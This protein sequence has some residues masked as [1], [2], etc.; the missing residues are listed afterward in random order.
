MYIQ[1][2]AAVPDLGSEVVAWWLHRPRVLPPSSFCSQFG[3]HVH[4]LASWRII[5]A[6][7][8]LTGELLHAATETSW[9]FL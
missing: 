8:I 2:H 1:V 6:G 3:E 5:M 4:F 7:L 9:R